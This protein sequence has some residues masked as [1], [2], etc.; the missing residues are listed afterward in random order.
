MLEI[1]MAGLLVAVGQGALAFEAP[2]LSAHDCTEPVK[3]KDT[4]TLD[5]E[6]TNRGPV[7]V[8]R[9]T[10]QAL[11]KDPQRT[12]PWAQAEFDLAV[13]GGIEP[14]ETR[15]IAIPYPALDS[16]PGDAEGRSFI[17][18][19]DGQ[20]L[21]GTSVKAIVAR[22][23]FMRRRETD[24]REAARMRRQTSP[25]GRSE[26]EPSAGAGNLAAPD[27]V[28]E[29]LEQALGGVAATAGTPDPGPPMTRG[30]MDAF[31][32]AVQQCWNVDVGTEAARVTLTVEFDLTP[33]GRLRGDVR[34][35]SAAGGGEAAIEAA[36]QSARRAILR[37]QRD[38]YVLPPDKYGHWQRMEM[39]FDPSGLHLRR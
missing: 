9:L 8:A 25:D 14:G 39:T 5:C 34:T 31:R 27:V 16:L 21:D 10:G 23:E 29:A 7:A 19:L 17:V 12:V 32:V 4:W 3:A 35:K 15:T 30:E 11:L 20:T 37:C 33:Q 36:F 38:G 18:G 13:P 24:R 6:V 28:A 26:A 2:T 1:L 22:R